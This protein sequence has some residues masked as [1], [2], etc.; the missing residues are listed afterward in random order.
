MDVSSDRFGRRRYLTGV[1]ALA[2][3]TTIAGC[4][5][6]DQTGATDVIMYGL[7]ADPVTLSVVITDA[8][9]TEPHTARTLDVSQGEKVDPVNRGKPPT[10]TN[11]RIERVSYNGSHTC[12]LLPRTA[13]YRRFT[14]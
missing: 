8:D 13:Q 4:L 11:Y 14:Y 7:A 1:T 3:A 6:W 5:S 2:G 12:S 9:T 10:N